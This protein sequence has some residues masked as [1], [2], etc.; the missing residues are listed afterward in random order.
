MENK[1]KFIL[2]GN[3]KWI[4][5]LFLFLIVQ[6]AVFFHLF[7]RSEMAVYDTWFRLNGVHNPGEKV[8]V[9]GIDETS[10]NRIGPL[11][12]PRSVHARLLEKLSEAK[13][14]G[15]D[16]TFAQPSDPQEDAA[17]A[18]AITKHGGVVLANAFNFEQDPNGEVIQI[19][20]MP[21]ELLGEGVAGIGFVNT[22]TDPDHVVRRISMVDVNTFDMP[23]PCL[24]LAMA[25]VAE[26]VSYMDIKLTPGLLNVG[27]RKIPVDNLNRA[28]PKFWG[29]RETFK[30]IS[31][32]DILEDKISPAFFKD[33]IVL[34][35]DTTAQGK[36]VYP[37]PFTTTNMVK[38]GNPPT[39]G[40]EIHAAA[41]QSFYD[42]SW[43]EQVHPLLNAFFLLLAGLVTSL[44]VTGKG[45]WRGLLSTLI[46]IIVFVGIAF[47]LWHYR[48]WIDIAAP[49][50]LIFLTYGAMTATDFV[51][52]EIG[53]RRTRAMF[54]RYVS[55]DVVDELMREPGSITLGGRRQELTVM[56]CDI[57]GFTAYSEN[58]APEDVVNRLNDYLTAVTHA[59]FKYGGT[60]DKYM[61]DG[62]MAI[63]G[64]PVFYPDHIERAIKAA[65]EIQVVIEGI[66]QKWSQENAPPLQVGVGINSGSVLVGNVG[67]PERMD[68]TVIGEDVN[69][70]SRVEG[71]TKHFGTLVVI[72]ERS[73]QKLS[74]SS[75]IKASLAFLGQA[76][77]KGFSEA[78]GCYTVNY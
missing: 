24:S 76:E 17:F 11:A 44:A 6:A 27:E 35:G 1:K 26:G 72:S 25:M 33:K 71:L 56:F 61:G 9:V 3:K 50:T 47:A 75:E 69:L 45:P 38:S 19:C 31:Y 18:E 37:T 55:P 68:Y 49:V 65:V 78:V 39:A 58:K 30:T 53:R 46:L 59:I 15:F 41:I 66:N 13:V 29:P 2:V 22:P 77:V 36:D 67:S 73:V 21:L 62:I 40:V 14:I 32:A 28:M 54:S 8:V 34:I 20:Q 10:I 64:A 23:I 12:W 51:Q 42:Q 43:Y 16:M 48:Q 74:A 57:R 52:A 63:F 60:L 7:E 70:A 4:L 5:P